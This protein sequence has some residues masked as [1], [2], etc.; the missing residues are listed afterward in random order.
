[1]SATEWHVDATAPAG[2]DGS[3]SAPFQYIQDGIDNAQPGDVVYVYGGT[4][5]ESLTTVRDGSA[6]APITVSA[7]ADEIV[8][9]TDSSR[10]LS[11]Q[12]QHTIVDGIN[13][14]GQFTDDDGM[15]RFYDGS[16]YSILRRSEIANAGNHQ[17]WIDADDVLIEDVYVHHAISNWGP[18][19]N[20]HNIH[21]TDASSVTIRRTQAAFATGDILHF[22]QDAYPTYDIHVEDCDF[23]IALLDVN[24]NGVIAGTAITD[25]VIDIQNST[26]DPN[27]FKEALTIRR[28]RLHGSFA[29]RSIEREAL[30]LKH[31]WRDLHIESNL[32]YDNELAIQMRAPSTDY[33]IVN[34]LIYANGQA[35]QF[36]D[37]VGGIEIANNT[38]Y[39]HIAI[40][41]HIGVLPGLLEWKNNIFVQAQAEEGEWLGSYDHNLFWL[42]PSGWP[43]LTQ[44]IEADPRL[45]DPS[46]LN[47]RLVFDSPAVDTGIY[48]TSVTT[49][50]EGVIRPQGQA[51]D[52]RAYE[53]TPG[54]VDNDGD[55]DLEDAG[56]LVEAIEGPALSDPPANSSPAGPS[57]LDGDGDIDLVDF[58]LLAA[59]FTGPR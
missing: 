46:G 22:E 36:E 56:A 47:F 28:C 31:R 14:D 11:L 51:Y 15:V 20:A 44:N 50:L 48:V 23:G 37:G 41:A 34:N 38:I 24:T 59:N 25:N 6:I 55:I 2:G 58:A 43:A 33:T 5:N 42:V 21:I 16:N 53:R 4:Y 1:M 32:L 13:F 10:V 8:W 12:N 57:D 27:A 49:D 29:S 19:T 40:Q 54:D 39:G 30:D 3:V 18:L 7:W 35:F 9:V 26:P 52:L 45:A 17:L